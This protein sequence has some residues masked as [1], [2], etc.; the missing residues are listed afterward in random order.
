[1]RGSVAVAGPDRVAI[2]A[3]DIPARQFVEIDTTFP[4]HLL[5]A[6]GGFVV[7]PGEGLALVAAR[8]RRIYSSPSLRPSRTAS[9]AAA[10]SPTSVKAGALKVSIASGA[11]LARPPGPGGARPPTFART[12]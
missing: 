7:R 2:D 9:A 12:G 3:S 11:L 5:A 1:V 10:N 6:A 4:R 8:E